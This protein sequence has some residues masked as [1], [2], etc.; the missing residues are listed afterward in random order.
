MSIEGHYPVT[1]AIRMRLTLLILACG[2]YGVAAVAGQRGPDAALES[3]QELILQWRQR[4]DETL[5]QEHGW[6]SLV[7]LDWLKQGE[8]RVGSSPDNDIRLSG[9]PDHWGTIVLT[10]KTLLFKRASDTDVTVDG[11][12]LEQAELVADNA[13]EPSVV[14]SGSIAFH[15]IFRESYAVRVSDSQAPAR[16]NFNGVENYE[17]QPRWR[18]T[19]RLVPAEAGQTIDI[20]NVLGQVSPTPVYGTFE[21]EWEGATYRLTGLG[22][23]SSDSVWFIF[24]DRTSGHGTYGAGRFLYSEGLPQEGRLVVDFN[25][26]YNPPCAFNDYSTCPLPP[27][28][29]RLD[30]AVTAGEKDVHP[31]SKRN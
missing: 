17:V 8:N 2:L 15:V 7:G 23:E 30:L 6:L 28:E 31:S 14:Q 21:F 26:A 25:K 3:E 12:M 20:G 13:G 11:G 16:L 24:A 18:I 9:G 19:G 5:R 4:R 27:Q 29:N 1:A 10:D 22:D